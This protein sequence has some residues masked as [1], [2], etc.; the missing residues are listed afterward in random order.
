[1]N[2]ILMIAALG[3]LAFFVIRTFTALARQRDEARNALLGALAKINASADAAARQ[4]AMFHELLQPLNVIRLASENARNRL[5]ARASSHDVEYLT[6]KLD[7]IDTQA[8]RASEIIEKLR[9]ER[10]AVTLPGETS[11]SDASACGRT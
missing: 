10:D 2:Q 9:S 5:T 3:G 11:T 7:R 1:M 6:G 4:R 8:L